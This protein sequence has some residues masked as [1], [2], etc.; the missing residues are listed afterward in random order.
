MRSTII[1]SSKFCQAAAAAGPL[2]AAPRS[3]GGCDAEAPVR[4]S[5]RSCLTIPESDRG[6]TRRVGLIVHRT[7]AHHAARHA[8]TRFSLWPRLFA[9][10]PGSTAWPRAEHYRIAPI[11]R[12]LDVQLGR[13]DFG[14]FASNSVALA[15]DV[16]DWFLLEVVG[17]APP[18]ALWVTVQEPIAPRRAGASASPPPAHVA[19][20]ILTSSAS[21]LGG[22]AHPHHRPARRHGRRRRGAA[23][24]GSARRRRAARPP[25]R[26][27]PKRRRRGSGSGRSAVQR[28]QAAAAAQAAQDAAAQA[29]RGRRRRHRG[30]AAAGRAVVRLQG[31]GRR[32]PPVAG[33]RERR[34]LDEEAAAEAQMRR[35]ADGAPRARGPRAGGNGAGRGGR[36]FDLPEVQPGPP[37]GGPPPEANRLR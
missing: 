22:G 4:P 28:Q 8:A 11:E 33:K 34:R 18:A 29:A 26:G 5:S 23:R 2:R 36:Q 13:R 3:R 17:A 19:S 6:C 9:T 20:C 7:A 30:A 37:G 35:D 10:F 1:P 12:P 32:P 31:P 15:Y 25:R 21:R 24:G 14:L 16:W 27:G